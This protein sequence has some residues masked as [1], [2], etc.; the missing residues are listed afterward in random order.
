MLRCF[1]SYVFLTQANAWQCLARVLNQRAAGRPKQL[2]AT[3]PEIL[4]QA[5]AEHD[6]K[7]IFLKLPKYVPSHGAGG[8]TFD[9][10]GFLRQ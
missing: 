9:A 1:A 5:R 6:R 8:Q 10:P 7:F 3:D 2:V 4:E